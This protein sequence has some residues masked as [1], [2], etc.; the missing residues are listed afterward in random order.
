MS[1]IAPGSKIAVTIT[2]SPSNAAAKK[3]LVRVLS[4]DAGV[5]KENA[6]LAKTRKVNTRVTVRGG[7]LRVWEGRLVKQ[8]PVKGVVGETGT[9]LATLDVLKDLA[10]VAA[11]VEVKAA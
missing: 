11:F 8:H 10:S 9:F 3:T 2:R 5:K 6:R 7:R 1:T 4:R